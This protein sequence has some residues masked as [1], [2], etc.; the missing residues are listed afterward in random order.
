M[1]CLKVLQS[2]ALQVGCQAAN[3]KV[4]VN[5]TPHSG[6]NTPHLF[7]AVWLVVHS[8]NQPA[9]HNIPTVLWELVVSLQMQNRKTTDKLN[10]SRELARTPLHYVAYAHHYGAQS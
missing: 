9:K 2:C 4:Y 10:W 1:F 7:C 5:Y 3:C 8:D 6:E